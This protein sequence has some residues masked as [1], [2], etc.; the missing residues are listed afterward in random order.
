[1]YGDSHNDSDLNYQIN[2]GVQTAQL[3]RKLELGN[4]IAGPYGT[5]SGHG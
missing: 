3:V 1:M 4:V 2:N 5:R